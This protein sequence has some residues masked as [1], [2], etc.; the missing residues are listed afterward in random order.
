VSIKDFDFGAKQATF[1]TIC[2]STL[3]L[4]TVYNDFYHYQRGVYEHRSNSTPVGGHAVRL[5]GWGI[6]DGVPYW[7]VANSWGT[8]WGI[9]GE[10]ALGLSRDGKRSAAG[11]FKIRRGTNEC[12]FEEY[13]TGGNVQSGNDGK[14]VNDVESEQKMCW[15]QLCKFYSVA[16]DTA[17]KLWNTDVGTNTVC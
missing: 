2:R 7:L 16:E 14:W 12:G 10:C 3:N 1:S 15:A 13:I 17:P 4:F 6:D 8:G 5:I 9:N 11:F